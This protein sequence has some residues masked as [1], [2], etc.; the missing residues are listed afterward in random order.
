MKKLTAVR[1]YKCLERWE[2]VICRNEKSAPIFKWFDFIVLNV[3]SFDSFEVLDAETV[4]SGVVLRIT[5]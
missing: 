4:A 2:G 3:V 1:L 5:N